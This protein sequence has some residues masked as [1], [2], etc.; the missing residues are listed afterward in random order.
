MALIFSG[1]VTDTPGLTSEGILDC[2][3]VSAQAEGDEPLTP[4]ELQ[5]LISACPQ[6]ITKV[7]FFFV[8]HHA[9]HLSSNSM[10]R[11]EH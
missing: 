8:L 7:C 2:D 11:S 5:T 1:E 10:L 4:E 6:A 3:D 9:F